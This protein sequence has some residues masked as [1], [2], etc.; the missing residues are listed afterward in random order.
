MW[1]TGNTGKGGG[2]T[3]SGG[4]G[5][6]RPSPY[7]EE[8]N[9]KTGFAPPVGI[10]Q[11]F[12]VRVKA[13]QERRRNVRMDVWTRFGGSGE[14]AAPGVVA[15]FDR[16]FDEVWG[17]LRAVDMEQQAQLSARRLGGPSPQKGS[18]PFDSDVAEEMA[19]IERELLIE[20][21]R[22][23]QHI[24][25]G[26]QQLNPSNTFARN[27]NNSNFSGNQQ[28]PRYPQHN[29]TSSFQG[30]QQQQFHPGNQMNFN[31]PSN[32]PQLNS[33]RINPPHAMQGGQY[34]NHGNSQ[35]HAG[36]RNP[37]SLNQSSTY[38][39]QT[40]PSSQSPYQ[41]SPQQ[42][43]SAHSNNPISSPQSHRQQQAPY[44]GQQQSHEP[45][46]PL[47]ARNI[48]QQYGQPAP[49]KSVPTINIPTQQLNQQN[50]QY[51]PYQ[52]QQYPQSQQQQQPQQQTARRG[53]YSS[54]GASSFTFG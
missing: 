9:N 25:S 26:S 48:N 53:Q 42:F 39:P 49:M 17:K 12:D 46:Y 22:Q 34:N 32:P 35:L 21:D 36:S 24:Q 51:P 40:Q 27:S 1:R 3:V 52:Q 19:K 16:A 20:L 14:P 6:R 47:S 23:P 38:S 33:A 30:N 37:T 45:V 13:M 50:Q 29:N 31:A 28:P 18:T 8:L 10:D 54:R 15:A 43:P 5:N 7:R 44:G 4:N 41:T 11:G 2:R